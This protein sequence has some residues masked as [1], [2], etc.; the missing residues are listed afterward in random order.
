MATPA[1]PPTTAV[2]FAPAADA[3]KRP[4]QREICD[5]VVPQRSGAYYQSVDDVWVGR[6]SHNWT[7]IDA[8][9][10]CSL[11]QYP[12]RTP[13]VALKKESDSIEMVE[14]RVDMATLG[15]TPPYVTCVPQRAVR[16]VCSQGGSS[17]GATGACRGRPCVQRGGSR[18]TFG[19]EIQRWEVNDE[20]GGRGTAPTLSR[21]GDDYR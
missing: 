15:T 9:A 20:P 2:W 13:C 14:D 1:P 21:E 17:R 18:A 5:D 3:R 6:T 19:N 11:A 7:A 10:Q 16:R 12:A 8:N 4:T